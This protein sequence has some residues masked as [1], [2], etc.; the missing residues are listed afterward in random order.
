MMHQ[1]NLLLHKLTELRL[2]NMKKIL[3][4]V[5]MLMS[6][7]SSAFAANW[8]EG[9][10]KGPINASDVTVDCT[11]FSNNLSCADKNVQHA[12][13]TLD[14][15]TGGGG[16]GT[17]GGSGN[18]VQYRVNS[19]TFGGVSGSGVDSN[20]NVGV[21]SVGPT[22]KLDVIGTVKANSLT[23]NNLRLF[24]GAAS[25]FG[26]ITL[27][28]SQYSFLNSGGTAGDA[29]FA[30]VGVSAISMTSATA[31][32]PTIFNGT[33]GLAS[34]SYSGNT[35][36]VVT[37]T[38][39]Q[40]SGNCVKI[41][42]NGNHVDAG[43][44]CGSGSG[45]GTVTSV[46]ASVP[47]F[48]SISGSPVTT[49]GT[50]AIGL[51]GTALPVLNGGSG[52]TT[53]TGSGNVVLST[54]PTLVTP[55]LGTPAS[56]V[57]TNLTG[58][59]LT[60]GVTGALSITNG[61][62][63]ATT[64]IGAST[65]IGLFQMG[66][67]GSGNVNTT[68]PTQ[69]PN[70]AGQMGVVANANKQGSLL[71]AGSTTTGD[72]NHALNPAGGMS[73]VGT[74]PGSGLLSDPFFTSMA[75]NINSAPSILNVK[76][77]DNMLGVNSFNV[78]PTAS[79]S[80]VCL[81]EVGPNSSGFPTNHSTNSVCWAD[82]GP[83]KVSGLLPGYDYFI[84]NPDPTYDRGF[85]FGWAGG[86]GNH[87][88]ELFDF[89]GSGS[90]FHT[91]FPLQNN[92][93]FSPQDLGVLNGVT[94]GTAG[95]AYTANQIV[96]V[97]Q[98]GAT[99]GQVIINTVSGGVPQTISVTEGSFTPNAGYGRNYS[100]ANGLS[101]TTGSIIDLTINAAGSGYV[102][103]DQVTIS[104]GDGTAQF[105]VLAVNS[106]GG[107][108]SWGYDPAGNLGTGYVNATGAATTGGTGTGLTFNTTTQ[109]GASSCGS[110]LAVNIT[111]IKNFTPIL[112]INN[113]T[114]LTQF[115][116]PVGIGTTADANIPFQVAGV[117]VMTTLHNTNDAVEGFF[118]NSFTAVQQGFY[119]PTASAQG[120][121]GIG[122][123]QAVFGFNSSGKVGSLTNAAILHPGSPVFQNILDD[124]TAN[125]IFKIP[126]IID[127]TGLQ[128]FLGGYT[129]DDAGSIYIR[130]GGTNVNGFYSFGGTTDATGHLFYT[131]G[132]SSGAET[133]RMVI[134]NNYVKVLNDNFLVST[135]NVGIGSQNPVQKLDVAGTVRA[136]GFVASALTASQPLILDSSQNLAT[137][138]YSGNTTKLA[139]S[140]G[141]LTNGDCVSI[142]ANGNYVDAGG[143]CGGSGST[144]ANPTASV[145]LAAV[146]GSAT[147]FLRSDGA[148]A[149]SQTIS[150]TMTGNWVFAPSSGNTLISAGNLGIGTLVPGQKLDVVGTVRAIAHSVLGGTSSQFQKADGSLDSS[151]YIT[152]NQTITA[153]GDATGSGT[154]SLPLTLATV[155][156]NVGSWTNANITVNA[157]GLITA[158]AN[159]T[160][161]S[162]SN[163]WLQS[164]GNV[165]I[166][167][168]APQNVG[169]GTISPRLPLQVVGNIGIGT[170]ASPS[171]IQD[172]TGSVTIV[173]GNSAGTFNLSMGSPWQVAQFGY[174][175]IRGN[176]DS[177]TT[178]TVNTGFDSIRG[179]VI[180]ANSGTQSANLQEWQ[181]S[182]GNPLNVITG[183]GNVGI[184]TS[185]PSTL[186]EVGVRKFNV[187]TGG[188]IGVGIVAPTG[189]IHVVQ[190]SGVAGLIADDETNDSKGTI[191]LGKAIQSGTR[192][193]SIYRASSNLN[194]DNTQGSFNF[195]NTSQNDFVF[196]NASQGSATVPLMIRGAGNIGIGTSNPLGGLVV[197]SG[198]V[199]IGTFNPT[200]RFV[201]SGSGT[202]GW[203]RK[204]SANQACSTTCGATTGCA[205]GLDQGT[206]GVALPNLVDCSDAT[207]DQCMCTGP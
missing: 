138:T 181:N 27:A 164:P 155:N 124:G 10:D 64:A 160:G 152:G 176:A 2:S 145:G 112:D 151:T 185:L 16:T 68:P 39:A 46:A 4:T 33:K 159:G 201:V 50:L 26:S 204:S 32:T 174:T 148:P 60:T 206:L 95:T 20:G 115:N 30:T 147:T 171:Q 19:S 73:F 12:L 52:T 143:A 37:T 57:A 110:G 76:Q 106:T 82:A 88:M 44:A 129:G 45:S 126:S 13:N 154:T 65:N 113:T 198:N 202:I 169:I 162:G 133:Q 149:L 142:D 157:K 96:N 8:V 114:G 186:L 81:G 5:L 177:T 140:S 158:A 18:Q 192:Q 54:S 36:Q 170:S 103:G 80:Q 180:K 119:N 40:T 104:G 205:F 134:N 125:H 200:G 74:N 34:G 121:I 139:T 78:S 6:T 172:S 77:Q 146:N 150:P 196:N 190:Q 108:I 178:L 35:T 29:Q 53:S 122:T 55:A 161:G 118:N 25:G 183:L 141:T 207:A 63:N 49:S 42:A 59:P 193:F 90:S 189:M 136:L 67:Y 194:M 22:Q 85:G 61:G 14:Q 83:N 116:L 28:N 195:N 131:G 84:H 203:T 184:G 92:N 86:T 17:P 109:C 70:F 93:A 156:S 31:N 89:E 117:N 153:S 175:G 107:V 23:S 87:L 123:A 120:N 127:T 56:G 41:D 9:Y 182:S 199:G 66:T 97:V 79:G 168:A 91:L 135:G 51:S 179:E 132:S 38:G 15:V 165:G 1:L 167:T 43:A 101:T 71:I 144:G 98:S 128:L 7:L 99:N 191:T 72:W 69:T 163:P 187:L 21:G 137:G 48:L 3:L 100:V 62:T 173:P 102:V 166:Y 24:D 111:S 58:L 11:Q 105:Y 130:K 47:A 94:I 75:I 188:N 197:M